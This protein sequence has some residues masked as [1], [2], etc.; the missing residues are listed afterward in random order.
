MAEPSEFVPFRFRVSLFMPGGEP[1]TL[2]CQG[3]FS[4][5]SG[6]EASMSPKALKEGGRNWGEVQ[7]AGPTNFSALVLKRGITSVQDLYAWFDVTT[8]QA[9][10]GFRMQ[11]LIEVFDRNF[12]GA[13]GKAIKKVQ[14]VLQWKI[15]RAMATKFKG[16]DLSSTAS[17]V[18]IE[19][20]HLA[21]EGLQMVPVKKASD[22]TSQQEEAQHG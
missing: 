1:D 3:A 19:E 15:E 2:V 16:P 14:P 17:Q 18:A 6:F 13:D 8:R 4:E 5:V 11:G 21:H 22:D 12:V 20:L 7:L 9:N 10:Y